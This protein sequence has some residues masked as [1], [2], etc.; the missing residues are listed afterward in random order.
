MI[1]IPDI[2]T[3]RQVLLEL[4]AT[5][6]EAAILEVAQQLRGNDRVL[7]WGKFV[8]A[9]RTG[10]SCVSNENGYGI[11]IP[12]A[13]TPHVGSMVMAAGRSQKGVFFPE[14]G[15]QVHYL[16]V[17]GVPAALAADYLRIIGALA[18][19]FRSPKSEAALRE[20]ET[21]EEFIRLLGA[22]ERS[23]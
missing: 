3:P 23:L 11:C 18:R 17:I 22:N 5:T 19:T 16:F 14:P 1:T 4:A 15:I 12:H 2:L 9:L 20:A 21:K 8:D 6:A 13:R 7:D 10:S